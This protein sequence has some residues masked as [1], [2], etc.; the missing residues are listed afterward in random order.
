ME[1]AY[2][3]YKDVC[4]CPVSHKKEDLMHVENEFQV[5]DDDVFNVT[6]PKSG[7]VW[8]IEI[9]SLIHSKGDQTLVKSIPNWDRAPWIETT[10][11]LAK[12]KS[13]PRPRLITSHLPVQLFPKSFFSSKAK[14]IYTA[15]NPKDMLVSLYYFAKMASMYDDPGSFEQFLDRFLNGADFLY[16]SWL[17]HVK[18]WMKLKDKPN[19]LFLTYEELQQDL[20]AGVVKVCKFLG[21][22]LDEKTIDLV[23]ENALFRNMK[24]NKMANFSTLPPGLMDQEKSKF[25]RKG[26]T[27]DWKN[28]FTVAQSENFDQVYQEKMKDLA[29]VFPWE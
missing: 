27:G 8:M 3:K 1:N 7:T 19:F 17:D 13:H 18:G 25:M 5:L 2:F 26:I 24:D 15:R 6:Y 28:H 23:V 29:A 9:L 11:S 16:G 4:F 21:K 22:E 20:R 14:V 12:L 10:E